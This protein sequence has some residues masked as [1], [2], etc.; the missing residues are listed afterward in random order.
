MAHG[1]DKAIE[2]HL[3]HFQD[4]Q[5]PSRYEH[6][7]RGQYAAISPDSEREE[8]E[9]EERAEGEGREKEEEEK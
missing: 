2:R 5:Y 7:G 9:E 8:E 6:W 4:L 1:G 3:A